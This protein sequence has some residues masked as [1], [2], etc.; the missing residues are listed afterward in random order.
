MRPKRAVILPV[1]L[2]VLVLIGLLAAMF[3]F[4]VHADLAATQV[5]A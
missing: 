4:R 1:V 2:F 3:A 5:M